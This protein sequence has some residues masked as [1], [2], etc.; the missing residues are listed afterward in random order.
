[1]RGLFQ[2]M[3]AIAIVY[4]IESDQQPKQQGNVDA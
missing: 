1:M 2:K 3:V 4:K